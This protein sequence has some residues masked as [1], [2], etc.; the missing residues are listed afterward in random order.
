MRV[1]VSPWQ[2][3]NQAVQQ[4][5]LLPL[6]HTGSL[7]YYII[8]CFENKINATHWAHCNIVEVYENGTWYWG[9]SV[10]Q[11]RHLSICCLFVE[12]L[13]LTERILKTWKI[14]ILELLGS[15]ERSW[16]SQMQR[17]ALKENNNTG[18]WV[19]MKC[20]SVIFHLYLTDSGIFCPE[21]LY[22]DSRDKRGWPPVFSVNTWP[23]R[24]E[25]AHQC[26]EST[27]VWQ[28]AQ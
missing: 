25:S 20:P 26:Q 27:V 6:S 23:P 24:S 10:S 21:M 12:G 19:I 28:D 14:Q 5:L 18:T 8:F 3:S 15:K 2:P 13:C 11:S 1:S 9:S 7:T 16:N 4:F 22:G 17:S